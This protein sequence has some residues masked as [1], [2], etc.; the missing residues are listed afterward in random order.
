MRNRGKLR[1]RRRRKGEMAT[2]MMM[3]KR[4]EKQWEKGKRKARSNRE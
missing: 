3:T 2:E 4:G 1:R